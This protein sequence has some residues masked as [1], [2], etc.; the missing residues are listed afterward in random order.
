M[1]IKIDTIYISGVAKNKKPFDSL[2]NHPGVEPCVIL[3]T[4][5]SS[6]LLSNSTK[7][8]TTHNNSDFKQGW[9]RIT[10]PDHS[11]LHW[12]LFIYNDLML[13]ISN[14]ILW[15]SESVVLLWLRCY[16]VKPHNGTSYLINGALKNKTL[17]KYFKLHF[18]FFLKVNFIWI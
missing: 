13:H 1:T 11:N 8:C 2:E 9:A 12:D 17:I 18:I 14:D 15:F 16:A 10:L 7:N 4:V 6:R 5:M 3:L